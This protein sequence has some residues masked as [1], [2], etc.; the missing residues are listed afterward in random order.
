M[1]G[2]VVTSPPRSDTATSVLTSA[3]CQCH[4]PSIWPWSGVP[5]AHLYNTFLGGLCQNL[6][7][8]YSM[9]WFWFVSYD[10]KILCT[11]STTPRFLLA[12]NV[13]YQNQKL[14]FDDDA[15]K[16]LRKICKPN[17]E[18]RHPCR[19]KPSEIIFCAL[20]STWSCCGRARASNNKHPL[21]FWSTNKMVF[22]VVLACVCS[23][24]T[25]DGVT[26][27]AR[28]LDLLLVQQL[29]RAWCVAYVSQWLFLLLLLL[30]VVVVVVHVSHADGD[31]SCCH[32]I[33]RMTLDSC[34]GQ[35]N[36]TVCICRAHVAA[37]DALAAMIVIVVWVL[38]WYSQHPHNALVVFV[39]KPCGFEA[40]CHGLPHC[41]WGAPLVSDLASHDG[42]VDFVHCNWQWH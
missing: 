6:T 36:I 15:I 32:C 8:V 34:P 1:P 26:G 2:E 16:C 17:Y 3:E 39:N 5:K 20:D 4:T 11:R 41:I 9:G 14:I 24:V 19:G 29:S 30:V 28:Q 42:F 35:K 18:S 13:K 37:I 23:F 31:N 25:E 27:S 12:W 22:F 33:E 10:F 7:I 38:L 40:D 21:Y